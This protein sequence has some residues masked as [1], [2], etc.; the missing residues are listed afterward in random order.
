MRS[1]FSRACPACGGRAGAPPRWTRP[2]RF[3]LIPRFQESITTQVAPTNRD[4]L[5]RQEARESNARSYPRRF[6]LALRSASGSRVTDVE[7]RTY[8]DCLAGASTLALGHDH[9][10]I[11]ESLREA[12]GQGIPLHTLDLATPQKDAFVEALFATL[13]PAFRE[14]ARIQFCSPSGSDAVEAAIK[15]AK[16]ATGP[17]D[18]VA[19]RGAYHG[20]SQGALSL[21]G[22]LGPKERLGTLMPGTHFLPYPH[23]Y[24]CPFGT[25]GADS[26]GL[27]TAVFEGAM[28]DPEGGMNRPAAIILQPVQGEGGVNPAP[29]EWL[30]QIRRTTHELG[31]PLILDEV[32]SGVGRTGTFYTFEKAGIRRPIL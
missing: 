27:A 20:M 14:G 28:R 9:P 23:A 10:E 6:P 8:L 29:V 24:R 4:F 13:P 11:V 19:F 5:Q 3:D 2:P 7:G 16:T 15:L 31:I 12:L 1:P 22:S 32:Q 17:Q 26:A 30:R 18:I 21:M 25:D